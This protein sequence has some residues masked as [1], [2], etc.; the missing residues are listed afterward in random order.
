MELL[1]VD[2][3]EE[4]IEKLNKYVKEPKTEKVKLE[5]ALGRVLAQAVIAKSDVPG[6]DRSTVDGYAVKS[7]N[8]QGASESVPGILKVTDEVLMGKEAK[9]HV[10]S[11]E[12]VYVPTGGMIPDGADTVVMTE[13]CEG[14][15]SGQI[16]VY[17]AEAPGKNIIHKGDDIGKGQVA[18]EKG[19]KLRAQDIGFLASLGEVEVECYIPWKIYIIS[20]GDEI[21]SPEK[22][23]EFGQIRDVNSYGL[24]SE[25]KESGFEVLGYAVVEDNYGKL[26]AEIEK[27]K[28]VA[29][30]VILSGGSSQGKKDMTKELINIEA[31]SRVLTHG[32]AIKPGKPTIIGYDE[33]TETGLIGLPGHPVAALM[34][35]RFIVDGIYKKVTN[36]NS[37]YIPHVVGKMATNVPASPGRKTI[38]LVNIDNKNEITPILGKSGLIRTMS[39]AN[40]YIILDVNCEGLN[41]GEVVTCYLF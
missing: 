33:V 4:A 34:L 2:L 19:K 31:S 32:I 18:F 6:F 3:L 28:E 29:D 17:K 20:T 11:L 12:A 27:G 14:F 35:F 38:Q 24:M 41:R 30:F 39:E 7:H 10:D 26:K 25:A 1:K 13:Y 5:D 9:M 37:R 21:V 8:I 15:S 36:Q 40:G 23:P 22:E 16:A